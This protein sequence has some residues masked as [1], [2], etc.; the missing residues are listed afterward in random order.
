MALPPTVTPARY[1]SLLQDMV[2]ER[3][4]APE[5]LLADTGIQAGVMA[6][7]DGALSLEQL[8]RLAANAVARFPDIALDL[9]ERIHLASHGILGFAGLTAA[10]V[11]DALAVAEKNFA[12][13]TPF[14]QFRCCAAPTGMDVI[15][16]PTCPIGELEGFLVQAILSSLHTQSRL[17]L[18][19]AVQGLEIELTI[20]EPVSG[21]ARYQRIEGVNFH[22]GCPRNRLHI[23][24]AMLAQ[25]MPMADRDAQRMALAHCEEQ[26]RQCQ[27][28]EQLGPILRK[29]LQDPAQPVDME[30]VARSLHMTTRT[31]RRHLAR[32]ALSWRQLLQDS[33]L[34]QAKAWLAAGESVTDIAVRL[35]Y[36]DSAN[37]SRAFKRQTGM[38]PRDFRKQARH[39]VVDR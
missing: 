14:L 30:S 29:R 21:L 3:G 11:E 10:T 15:L 32:E 25:R 16:Q 22:F 38:N 4:M 39:P 17:L 31:L 27:G 12:L 1:F 23:P 33:R 5:S 36:Q 7:P 35:D 20:P 26:L 13:V 24:A 18:G 37:F 2:A 9:G 19:Q 6:A 28:E 34:E 8:Q